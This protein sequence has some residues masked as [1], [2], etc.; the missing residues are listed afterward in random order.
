[1]EMRQEFMFLPEARNHSFS[2]HCRVVDLENKKPHLQ[3][4]FQSLLIF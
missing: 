2:H 3:T 4:I 1:M